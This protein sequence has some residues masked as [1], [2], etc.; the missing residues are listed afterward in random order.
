MEKKIF[1]QVNNGD[2]VR[3]PLSKYEKLICNFN[4]CG[5]CIVSC[6]GILEEINSDE[7][8]IDANLVKTALSYLIRRHPLMRSN[9]IQTEGDEFTLGSSKLSIDSNFVLN[10]DNKRTKCDDFTRCFEWLAVKTRDEM[11]ATMEQKNQELFDF[12]SPTDS[13]WRFTI[14]ELENNSYGLFFLM[15]LFIC[16]GL[17]ICTLTVELTNIINSLILKQDCIEMREQLDLVDNFDQLMI[18]K[19][20]VDERKLK[21]VKEL[22]DELSIDSR[23]PTMFN[24]TGESGLKLTL[25]KLSIELTKKLIELTKVHS[26]KMTGLVSAIVIYSLKDLYEEYEIRFPKDFTFGMSANLRFG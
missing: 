24:H 3:V 16:D 11:I 17:C 6:L 20:L 15:P 19:S 18:K 8:A 22:R 25:F 7:L 9:V 26:M 5:E 14:F 1:T 13:I 12:K 10:I 4:D 23:L 2:S 21:H